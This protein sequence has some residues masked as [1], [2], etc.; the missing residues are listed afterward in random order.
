MA[1]LIIFLSTLKFP[2][3]SVN[4]M[5]DKQSSYF[6]M[7]EILRTSVPT[8]EAQECAVSVQ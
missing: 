4:Y 6:Y 3:F 1:V 8:S 7:R 5:Y 2:N